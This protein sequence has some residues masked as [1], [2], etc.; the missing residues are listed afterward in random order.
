MTVD[1]A[2]DLADD[3]G[4]CPDGKEARVRACMH[5]MVSGRWVTG[6][7]GPSVAAAWALNEDTLKHYAAEASRRVKA[8]GEAGWVKERLCVA[9]DDALER[10][11]TEAPRETAAV[12]RAYA[13]IAQVTKAADVVVEVQ[14]G[15][16]SRSV[17]AARLVQQFSALRDAVWAVLERHPEA[18]AD[19]IA[20]LDGMRAAE[21]KRVQ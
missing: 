6:E 13:E 15:G 17:P 11:R 8:A 21:L 4:P 7:T 14:I 18:L 20:A 12:A 16:V 3:F 2:A 5:L 10:A 1:A 19:V 9:L